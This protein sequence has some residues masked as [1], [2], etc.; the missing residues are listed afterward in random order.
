MDLPPASLELSLALLPPV[1]ASPFVPTAPV[2]TAALHPERPMAAT[3]ASAARAGDAAPR[4][5]DETLDNGA[6]IVMLERPGSP[7]TSIRLATNTG[8]GSDPV[9]RKH[10]SHLVEHLWFEGTPTRTA[11]QINRTADGMGGQLNAYTGAGETVLTVDVPSE[12]SGRAS[13]MLIDMYRNPN[14]SAGSVAKEQRAVEHEIRMKAG[15]G[16]SWV[17]D[18]WTRMLAGTT[19]GADIWGG[20]RDASRVTVGDAKAWAERNLVG[21][22]TVMVVDGDP[23]SV[24][25]DRIREQ[26]S[27]LPAGTRATEREAETFMQG[28][29]QVTAAP[30]GGDVNATVNVAVPIH[31]DA[32]RRLEAVTKPGVMPV[33]DVILG[34][35]LNARLRGDRHMTYGVRSGA[36][37][38]GVQV[39]TEVHPSQAD[40]A[41]EQITRTIRRLPESTDVE[42]LRSAKAVLRSQ[43]DMDPKALDPGSQ[44]DLAL[45]QALAGEEQISITDPRAVSDMRR[46]LDRVTLDDVRA[47]ARALG[48]ID[49]A[50]VMAHGNVR[51]SAKPLVEA[52]RRGGADVEPEMKVLTEEQAR[53]RY[54]LPERD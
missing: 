24:P 38:T 54:E 51:A 45:E 41:V 12:H 3:A 9:G 10:L 17:G 30:S 35:T 25:L 33:L 44:V 39:Q 42:S 27:R 32:I 22:N 13:D 28:G 4:V 31:R 48:N 5:H 8:L 6:R 18:E 20:T 2:T 1:S 43:L 37:P 15:E 46:D 19:A 53:R 16:A 47:A 34:S 23:K 49:E 7:S 14:L 11:D 26:L 36:D 40:D 52:L 29:S 50:K 21:A